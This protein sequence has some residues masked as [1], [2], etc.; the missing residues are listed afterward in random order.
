M[1]TAPGCGQKKRVAQHVEM[2]FDQGLGTSFVEERNGY[3]SDYHQT[4]TSAPTASCSRLPVVAS[5]GIGSVQAVV[6]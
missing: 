4:A 6:P 3:D 1:C 2:R 5:F